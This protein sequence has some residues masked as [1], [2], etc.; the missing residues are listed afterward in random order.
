MKYPLFD[1]YWD[2]KEIDYV[3]DVI[4]RGSYWATGPEI[5]EFESKIA[6]YIGIK[7]V[8]AFNSGTSAEHALLVAY[9]LTGGEIIVP[10]FSF[11]STV[12]CVVLAGATPVFADIETSSMG[13]DPVDVERKITD[14]TK[15]II[16]MHYAGKACK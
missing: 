5:R 3:K 9:G 8:I 12:N 16:P 11:I 4:T 15:A 13:L 14:R 6:E 1:I 7:Y 10:S 2:Q